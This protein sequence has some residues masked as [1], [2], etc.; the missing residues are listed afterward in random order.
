MKLCT[1]E[2]CNRRHNAKWLCCMHYYRKNMSIPMEL[3][4]TH[5]SRPAI[6][7]WDIAKI[8][9]WVNA[10]HWY[11]IVDAE[12]AYI[13][14]NNWSINTGWY[15]SRTHKKKVILMHHIILPK[16]K[17][18]NID[19]INWNK[20]DN[21]RCNLRVVSPLENSYNRHRC[22]SNNISWHLWV[23]YRRNSYI[24]FIN[25]R[26]KCIHWWYFKILEDAIAK[27][28][29]LEKIYIWNIKICQ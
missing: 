26:W 13:G 8:P 1:I 29:E 28:K 21:R 27:R 16:I 14:N 4:S 19:H 2:W 25:F 6:I 15:A 18:M 9:L 24:A 20:L 22:N 5:K 12:C 11:A 23:S 17:W 7:E 3:Q 10:K